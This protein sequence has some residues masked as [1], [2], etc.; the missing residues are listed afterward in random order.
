MAPTAVPPRPSAARSPLPGRCARRPA[1]AGLVSIAFLAAC[2]GTTAPDAAAP[3]AGGDAITS[4]TS[5]PDA[6]ADGYV[7]TLDGGALQGLV[8]NGVLTLAGVPAGSHEVRLQSVAP[9]CAVE[10]GAARRVTVEAG[11]QTA[12]AFTVSCREIERPRGTLR[13]TTATSGPS[14]DPDGYTA[15]LEHGAARTFAPLPVAGTVE[16]VVT[17]GVY[18]V[19]LEGVESNCRVERGPDGAARLVDV[20]PDATVA[21]AF[22]VA[23]AA[24]APLSQLAFVRGGQIFL[25]NADGTGVVRLTEGP[26]DADPAW[27]PDG[28][29][30]AFARTS[31]PRDAWGRAPRDIY[32]MDAD[33]SRLARRSSTGSARAPTWSPDG[34]R[35]AFASQCDGQ[36]CI[37]VTS[38]DDETSPTRLGFERG[39]HDSPAWSPDGRKIAFVS[40]RRAYDF[41]YDL[42]V[43]NA[44]GSGAPAVLVEG[45]FPSGRTFYF[46]P[47]WAPDG[48]RIA[49]VVCENTWDI[50]HP[51]G[52]V[53]VVRADG[54]GL[55]RLAA[56]G[57]YARPTW[58]PD[59]RSLAFASVPCPECA[60]SIRYVRADGSGEGEIVANGHSPAWR[61]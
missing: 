26:D 47:A 34:R 19:A 40:D 13:I 23:C 5:G 50:C 24:A 55:T 2:G 45:P 11:R 32:V 51:N 53:A 29:R 43:M 6:D 31:G 61:P 3:A 30:I 49:V 42:Y 33:G 8:A 4:A 9:N 22:A 35:I 14:P 25:V 17:A 46:Q 52:A 12:V 41:V 54:S 37:Y 57:G 60:A 20:Q 7:V 38:A 39:F 59:G 1:V 10:G 15:R 27:S 44:D 21:V 58:A 56:A 48:G 28:R 36:G 18:T 16:M